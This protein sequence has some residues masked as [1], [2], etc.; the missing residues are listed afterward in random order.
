VLWP[1]MAPIVGALGSTARMT[2]ARYSHGTLRKSYADRLVHIGDAAH[3]ASPQLGQASN[4][5]LLDAYALALAVQTEGT[6]A[7]PLYVRLYQAMSALFTPQYQSGRRV[8]PVIHDRL[9]MPLSQ[10]WPVPRI[11]TRLVG[12]DLIL[13]LAGVDFPPRTGH[14]GGQP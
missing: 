14:A 7:G 10:M 2:P 4:I 9:L 13:P 3:R 11:L 8:L 5:A 12:G 6:D 1:Q